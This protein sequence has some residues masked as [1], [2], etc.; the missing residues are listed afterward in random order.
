VDQTWR[1]LTS[2]LSGLL[3][4][5]LNFIDATNTINPQFSFR[6]AGVST[7]SPD[8]S[9]LR[10]GTLPQEIVCTEN[11]TPW[12][13]LLPCDS[14]RGLAT[15][16]N[17]GYIHNTNYHSL[18][19]H[20]R[21]VCT[22]STCSTTSVELKQS[23]SLVHDL[24]IVE[25]GN[26]DFSIRKLFGSGLS[27]NCPLADSSMIYFDVTNNGTDGTY[28][29]FP[30]PMEKITSIRT[31][32]QTNLAVYD[33][34]AMKSANMFNVALTYKGKKLT[35]VKHS[36]ILY[37]HRF[38]S[39]YGQQKGGIV[40]KLVNRHWQSVNVVLL[41][42]VPWYLPLYLHSLTVTTTDGTVIKPGR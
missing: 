26:E 7:S 21:N 3:C 28:S 31:G 18:G 41:E 24:V 42:N 29:L 10:Y 13:K 25:N 23:V 15:L 1:E 14:T 6:P 19:I 22:D 32:I 35:S 9:L 5:S 27:G 33:I 8:P 17:A 34:K 4:A 2:S 16:L 40:T 38:V 12:K 30:A 37:T 39:G 11:L 36:P 20:V